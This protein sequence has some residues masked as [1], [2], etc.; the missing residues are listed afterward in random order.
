MSLKDAKVV[1]LPVSLDL[2]P[3][4]AAVDS[5]AIV[6]FI[7]DLPIC[8]VY[9]V[10][11]L[12]KEPGADGVRLKIVLRNKLIQIHPAL[13]KTTPVWSYDI[14]DDN[15]KTWLTENY[16]FGPT[17]VVSKGQ[18]IDVTYVNEIHGT[19]PLSVLQTKLNSDPNQ[20][21]IDP[22][23]A[24]APGDAIVP[25]GTT[26]TIAAV[27]GS[28]A[29]Y[30]WTVTHLHGGRTAAM[31]DGWTENAMLPPRT[32][33]GK[34]SPVLPGQ[35]QTSIYENNQ[36]ATMLWYHDHGMGITRLNVV[37]GL[38]GAYLITDE[39]EIRQLKKKG[40]VLPAKDREI[41]LVIQDRNLET[42]S[43]GKLTGR[44][45]HKTSDGTAE[46]FAP[47]T[48]VNGV[49]WPKKQVARARYRLRVLNGS[50]ART[51][52][53][54]AVG[55]KADGGSTLLPLND[56]VRQIG[57]DGGLLAAPAKV[58]DNSPYEP[59]DPHSPLPKHVPPRTD[60]LFLAPAERADLYVDF[61]LVPA[62]IQQIVL[63]NTAFAPFH[64][65]TIDHPN[66]ETMPDGS[67]VTAGQPGD[68]LNELRLPFPQVMRF[69]LTSTRKVDPATDLI[70]PTKPRPF[71]NEKLFEPL[72]LANLYV[73]AKGPKPRL[74]I[75]VEDPGGMLMMFEMAKSTPEI[76]K[77]FNPLLPGVKIKLT[78]TD[79]KT[80][81][82][83][84]IATRFEDRV[85]FFPRY[86]AWEVWQVL[87]LTV[88]THPF[89][90]HLSQFRMLQRQPIA[91]T[92]FTWTPLDHPPPPTPT[93]KLESPYLP[94]LNE[95]GW[96]DTMRVNPG[97]MLTFAGRFDGF[98]GRYMYHCHILEHEDH[99]MMRPFV[100]IPPEVM[101][102]TPDMPMLDGTDLMGSGAM[103]PGMPGMGGG[104][105]SGMNGGLNGGLKT[106]AKKKSAAGGKTPTP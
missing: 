77:A 95:R 90:V 16:Y 54:K 60:G 46:Y 44:F 106:R 104:M 101:T 57:S 96:K 103:P 13:K 68:A 99:E 81:T 1:S 74:V 63:V 58:P 31:Y 73:G 100:V 85:A 59:V 53:L 39:E 62:D 21:T 7:D 17:I 66:D 52:C 84:P 65:N 49:I 48:L 30:A 82:Y 41:P 98:T 47:F 12:K 34:K 26:A 91:K 32:E 22:L 67:P 75:L 43:K 3:T 87:N 11:K 29:L 23:T 89:H 27:P 97:E 61:G 37:S 64:R 78:D 35:N 45:L 70:N 72:K 28:D 55:I 25:P 102:L 80:T 15:T 24:N 76:K 86:G 50:N 5:S 2:A 19:L 93:V 51:Y 20:A 56:F 92:G 38:V 6:P 18:R 105:G 40:I 88:D 42:N 69:D 36:R 14:Y 33:Q 94:D 9:D 4:A 79:D 71:Y 83:V 8:P 10:R